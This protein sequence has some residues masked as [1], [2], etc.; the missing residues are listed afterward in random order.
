MKAKE[1][2]TENSDWFDKSPGGEKLYFESEVI[3]MMN[4]Y[5]NEALRIHDVSNSALIE[6]PK[7]EKYGWHTQESFDDLPSGWQIEGGE[8]AYEEALKKYNAQLN[9]EL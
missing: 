3:R 7:K 6:K 8:E 1:F 4:E 2:L 5:A 9:K